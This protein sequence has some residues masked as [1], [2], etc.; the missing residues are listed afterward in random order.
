MSENTSNAS[1]ASN[2][3][4]NEGF[5]NEA[6]Y[7]MDQYIEHIPTPQVVDIVNQEELERTIGVLRAK[8]WKSREDI[9]DTFDEGVDWSVVDGIG[10]VRASI[11]EWL[12]GLGEIE[13]QGV[14]GLRWKRNRGD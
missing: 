5:L 4:K 14:T 13:W 1:N 2:A 10:P 11:M 3:S 6:Q 12:M 9:T 7:G 8:G